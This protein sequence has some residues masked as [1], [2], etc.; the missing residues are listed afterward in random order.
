MTRT[1]VSEAILEDELLHEK[2]NLNSSQVTRRGREW[3]V[4]YWA[5]SKIVRKWGSADSR[6]SAWSYGTAT[7][8]DAPTHPVGVGCVRMRSG[9]GNPL[10]LLCS[11]ELYN[12]DISILD[13]RVKIL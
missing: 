9:T 10:N 4:I 13:H 5:A 1:H 3:A 8:S 2:G 11:Y 7:S 6:Q 12:S